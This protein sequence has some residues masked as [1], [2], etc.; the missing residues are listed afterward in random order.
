MRTIDQ[1]LAANE[2]EE[3]I[4][5]ILEGTKDRLPKVY[6]EFILYSARFR[7]NE[8]EKNK[9]VLSHEY[10]TIEYNR[11]FN[12]VKDTY[13]RSKNIL[14]DLVS[15]LSKNDTENNYLTENKNIEKMS[16]SFLHLLQVVS[17]QIPVL[18][19]LA[20]YLATKIADKSIETWIEKINEDGYKV[21]KNALQIQKSTSLPLL[22]KAVSG[23][24]LTE[25]ES[26]TLNK[27]MLNL[28]QEKSF[29]SE[30]RPT[31]SHAPVGVVFT[32][33][34]LLNLVDEEEFPTLFDCFRIHKKLFDKQL[35]DQ[36]KYDQPEGRKLN[37]FKKAL[38]IHINSAF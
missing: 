6:D 21:T 38:K 31:I 11:I 8:N 19:G 22:E 2:L 23:V 4:Q 14:D 9:G 18:T 29:Q 7:R 12:A 32:K 16:L 37:N 36:S 10:Y 15:Q 27:E 35:E 20:T 3:A 13:K 1:M 25:T 34:Y 33:E 17:E 30:L 5:L 26:E 28:Y 24:A